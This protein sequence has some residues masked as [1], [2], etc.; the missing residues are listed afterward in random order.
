MSSMKTVY[1]NVSVPVHMVTTHKVF[2][3]MH[4][5]FITINRKS[6]KSLKVFSILV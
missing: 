5:V 4:Y 2:V 3:R 6:D 1:T